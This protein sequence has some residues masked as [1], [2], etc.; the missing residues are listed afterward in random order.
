VVS[1][2]DAHFRFGMTNLSCNFAFLTSRVVDEDSGGEVCILM[3]SSAV[4]VIILHYFGLVVA[5]LRL[6]GPDED[7]FCFLR[8][9]GITCI[10]G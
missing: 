5:H 10:Q 7:I 2:E 9:V 1:A 6:S 8:A 4:S 3:H